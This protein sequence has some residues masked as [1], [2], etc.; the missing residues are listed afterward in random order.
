MQKVV[1]IFE[2]RHVEGTLN[3][4]YEY[5]FTRDDITIVD[6]DRTIQ[7]PVVDSNGLIT[8]GASTDT[9]PIVAVP[10]GTMATHSG[11]NYADS[12]AP[13]GGVFPALVPAFF[14]LGAG[15]EGDK[16]AEFYRRAVQNGSTLIIVRANDIHATQ[17]REIMRRH[18][19]SNVTEDPNERSTPAQV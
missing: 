2:A 11:V 17:A 6:Q 12:L 8:A 18:H 15:A 4:L 10:P 7:G 5:G 14:G 19:A 1:G 3:A 9:E 13:A 16:A